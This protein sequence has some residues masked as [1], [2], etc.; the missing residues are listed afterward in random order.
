MD[1][2]KINFSKEK[3]YIKKGII[4]VKILKTYYIFNIIF[5][6][7][8]FFFINSELYVKLFINNKKV[9]IFLILLIYLSILNYIIFLIS[10]ILHIIPYFFNIY[11]ESIEIDLSTLIIESM[12]YKIKL[13]LDELK[14]IKVFSYFQEKKCYLDNHF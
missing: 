13:N 11:S 3:I 9:S 5:T 10:F 8:F 7:I 12:N 1:N 6:I 2:I 14:E 4:K